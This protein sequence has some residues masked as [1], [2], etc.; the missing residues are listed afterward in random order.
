MCV[1]VHRA[2]YI[3]PRA[4]TLTHS[5]PR[6]GPTTCGAKTYFHGR[7]RTP[8]I[9]FAVM[10]RDY[11]SKHARD[12]YTFYYHH[13]TQHA[14]T[15]CT[16]VLRGLDESVSADRRRATM[17]SLLP[18]LLRTGGPKVCVGAYEYCMF[19]QLVR[20]DSAQFFTIST[21]TPGL[22]LEHQRPH[23]MRWRKRRMLA[24]SSRM[25]SFSVKA[26]RNRFLFRRLPTL[27]LLC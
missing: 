10:R 9:H 5:H 8:R 11:T 15:I 18:C 20:G 14:A 12:V 13:F 1:R 4:H 21:I 26:T 2:P 7:A 16:R 19:G 22:S 17:Q 6:E 27:G 23:S 3:R 25:Q 24:D